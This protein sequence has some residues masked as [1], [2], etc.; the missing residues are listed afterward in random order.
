MLLKIPDLEYF[1][2]ERPGD[3][4]IFFLCSIIY[5]HRVNVKKANISALKSVF[6]WDK[7]LGYF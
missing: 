3:I 6:P 5:H 7:K 2:T 1:P 4:K